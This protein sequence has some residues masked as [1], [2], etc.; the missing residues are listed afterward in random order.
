MMN[1]KDF[2]WAEA[3]FDKAADRENQVAFCDLDPYDQAAILEFNARF[4]PEE[5]PNGDV[6]VAG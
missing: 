2:Q 5:A 1:E 6:A 4:Q 3:L